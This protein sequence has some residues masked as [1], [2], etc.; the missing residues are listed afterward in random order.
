MRFQ[1]LSVE[2]WRKG[3]SHAALSVTAPEDQRGV[4]PAKAEG[5]RQHRI[6]GPAP[7]L[8]RHEVDRG[9]NRRIVEIERRRGDVVADGESRE[10][11]LD[12][13]RRAEQMADGRLCRRPT[14]FYSR[15]TD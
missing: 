9:H 15:D 8:V 11:R 10:N 6:D 1:P 4:G 13:A 7:G 3:G 14:Y 12:R 5:I 2:I